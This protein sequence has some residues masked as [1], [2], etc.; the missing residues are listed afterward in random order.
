MSATPPSRLRETFAR[1]RAAGDAVLCPY[2]T[3]GHPDLAA[4][5]R[6]LPRLAHAGAGVIEIGFPFSDP[7]ADG[8]VIAAAMDRAIAA[9]VTTGG[10]LAAI[11]DARAT[12][13]AA[14]VGMISISLLHAGGL[15][16]MTAALA[17]AG[18]DGLI[19]PDL[20]LDQAATIADAGRAS[21]LG[22]CP[23]IAPTTDAAR[24]A[25]LAALSSGFV[26]LLARVGLTGER[27]DLPDRAE[28]LA[29]IEA[30][31]R[32][33]DTPVVVGFGISDASQA[34]A[35]SELADGVI[36][37]SALV[38]RMGDAGPDAPEAAA[39][40]TAELARAIRRGRP[41]ATA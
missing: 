5:V 2:I 33:T 19:V 1:A 32:V 20:D 22:L 8:P 26:Y 4:T 13:P 28:L 15:E 39:A 37:G 24:V 35:I 30:V 12:V 3:G 23:L 21:G 27:G 14:L 40:W 41:P 6:T 36:V 34:A 29:R 16:R 10:L 18:F 25:R 31:H 7:I 9:G 17:A 38:R 11:R